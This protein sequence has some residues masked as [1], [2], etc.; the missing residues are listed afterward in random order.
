MPN[1]EFEGKW[2]VYAAHLVT[3]FRPLIPD[4]K[5]SIPQGKAQADKPSTE[6]NLII[7]G[8]NLHALRALLPRYAGRIHCVYID[9]PYN[10]GNEGWC[11]NDN[12]NSPLM[13]RWLKE[14]GAV[15]LE[16]EERHDKW[17]C[18]MW[19]RLQLLRELLAEDGVI[20]ITVD[21]NEQHRLRMVMD[22]I[23]GED[24][25]LACISWE[26]RYTRNNNAKMFTSVVDKLVVYRKS[27][28]LDFLRE[29]RNTKADEI[30]DNPDNDPRGPWTSVSYVNPATREQ[31]PNLVYT[32]INPCTKKEVRHPTNAWKFEPSEH[33]KHV[34]ENRLWWGK[35]GKNKFPRLKKFLSEV[36][37]GLV[38]VDL[39]KHE[40][41]GTTDEGSLELERILGRAKFDNPKPTRLIKRIIRL[42]PHDNPIVLDS[43]A[44]S[45]TTA[46]AVLELNK[47]DEG[48][49]KFILVECEDYANK[50]TAERIRRVIKGIKNTKDGNLQQ[51][52]GGG[53][54]YCTLGEALDIESMLSG[55]NLPDYETIARCIAHNYTGLALDKVKKGKD[56]L[57]AET[58]RHC[59]HLIYKPDLK[60]LENATEAALTFELSERI[61]KAAVRKNKEAL[62]FASHKFMSQ[63]DLRYHKV[64]F[65]QIPYSVFGTAG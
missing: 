4:T 35:T 57:F 11:Y 49:R 39:W 19:P 32:I 55:E 60:F 27:E 2:N 29:P 44:G 28:L 46:Q 40:D 54:T 31:R 12:L 59:L 52:L 51:G 25:F 21:D 8:D 38:P 53:F 5:K 9:P 22:E 47:E 33:Q 56:W 26:K 24:N 65:C 10:T 13:K 50:I 17:L 3:P 45:G 16:D 23:F 37:D 43:F 30:Y 7:Q 18:M 34:L 41:S 42:C 1:I 62:V 58:D 15:D 6:G 36:S 14:N 48:L 20:F 64:T 61:G 63:K